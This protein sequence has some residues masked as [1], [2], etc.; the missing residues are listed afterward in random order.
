M[1]END[2]VCRS[3]CMCVLLKSQT[4]SLYWTQR[5]C[6]DA[7]GLLVLA[8]YW[9]SG[10]DPHLVSDTHTHTHTH[11]R[12]HRNHQHRGKRRN[13]STPG[14][15]RKC[16]CV[17]VCVS[18]YVCDQT[19]RDNVGELPLR[20][21]ARR[22]SHQGTMVQASDCL[23]P[24]KLIEKLQ[25]ADRGNKINCKKN[26]V[27]YLL[28]SV[29]IKAHKTCI[30]CWLSEAAFIVYNICERCCSSTTKADLMLFQKM[31]C[32]STSNARQNSRSLITLTWL[33]YSTCQRG[34]KT[35]RERKT[36]SRTEV[37][38][39]IMAVRESASSGT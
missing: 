9:D 15:L 1:C 37:E 3:V 33:T 14:I 4:R 11:A 39:Q 20:D 31:S 17:G 32:K 12:A 10:S 2:T 35:D 6:H 26:R 30:V 18:V 22:Q 19:V 38:R 29:W 13:G 36:E 34:R 28:H 21:F 25:W 24:L 23:Y 8:W 16:V 7:Q 5:S 27:Y